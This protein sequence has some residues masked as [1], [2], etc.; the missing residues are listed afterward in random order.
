MVDTNSWMGKIPSDWKVS[1]IGNAYTAR[2]E[3]VS[4]LDYQPL[5]VTMKGVVPQLAT[6]AKSDIRR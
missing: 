3:K 4:D 5:S 1:K 6:A 2:N